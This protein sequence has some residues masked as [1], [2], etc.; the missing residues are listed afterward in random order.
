MVLVVALALAAPARAADD[1][2][3]YFN[4]M[5]RL[6]ESLEY[7][8]ALEQLDK[9]HKYS[10]GTDDDVALALYEGMIRS[11][12]G[13]NDQARAAFKTALLLRPDVNFPVKVSPK[14]RNTFEDLRKA[15]KKELAPLIEKQKAE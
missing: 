4:A 14:V 7:E 15:V 5:V 12:L 11:D 1:Y 10:R 13:Q 9:A 6:Y 3:N 2:A 8:R